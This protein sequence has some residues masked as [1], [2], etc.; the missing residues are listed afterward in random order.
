MWKLQQLLGLFLAFV[1]ISVIQGAIEEEENVLVLTDSN[2]EEAFEAYDPILV[3]FYAPWC[4][5]CKN[6][7]PEYARAAT[8]LKDEASP[9]RLAKVDSTEN[10]R[11]AEQFDIRGFPTLKFFKGGMDNVRE[12]DGG[13]TSDDIKHWVTK[14]SGPA[15]NII[16]TAEELEAL[17]EANDVVVFAH[18]DDL[19]GANRQILERIA[20]VD[21]LIVAA[22]STNSELDEDAKTPNSVVLFKKFDEGKVVFDG[23][24]TEEEVSAFIDA[25]NKPL[26]IVFEQE[27]AP[28]IF[29]GAI[30]QHALFFADPEAE[31]FEKML[32]A[33]RPVAK[34]SKGKL[35]H[36][37][38]PLS[39]TRIVEYFGISEKESPALVIVNM[40]GAMRKFYFEAKGQEFVEKI[41][42]SLQDEVASFEEQYFAGEIDPLLKSQDPVDDSEEAVKVI[43]GNEFK[44]RVVDTDKDVLLEFYAPW[45]GHCKHL[46]PVYQELAEKFSSVESI[47]IAKMDAT[48]N[49]V[50]HPGV[51]VKGFPTIIF[52]PAA[53]K[54]NPVVY[55]GSRDLEGMTAFLKE[56]AREFDL[57]DEDLE[58]GSG[59][60]DEAGDHDEL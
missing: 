13:R 50:D 43:V 6:L 31:Y 28:M 37:V 15:V 60:E 29:G 3:E 35:L 17:K 5:H 2:F 7:A 41:E 16:E 56:N 4:G 39:E 1:C 14:K 48:E 20:D 26:V 8:E 19:E 45:C 51:D 24:F 46:A 12:Y 22:A 36:V 25:N 40:D 27:R 33:I 59:K 57:G 10:T 9:I 34:A 54:M 18:F 44:E 47:V 58:E 21:D 42:S 38:I 23:E 53:D 49:E 11:L 30:N 32:D 55:E 52:F